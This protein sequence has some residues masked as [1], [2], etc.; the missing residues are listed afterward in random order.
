[1]VKRILIVEDDVLLAMDMAERLELLGFEILG[2][3]MTAASAMDLFEAD[4]CDA[5]VL[6]INLGNETSEAVAT[7]LK[8]K[9]VP[10]VVSSGYSVDQYPAVYHDAPAVSKPVNT[11]AL[12]EL[13][14]TATS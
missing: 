11:D 2:P 8:S 10:F 14:V 6:D 13:L 3:C 4:P 1:M 12:A 7:S 5:A 9:G